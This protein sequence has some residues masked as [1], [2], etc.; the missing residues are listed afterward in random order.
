MPVRMRHDVRCGHRLTPWRDGPSCALG[1]DVPVRTSLVDDVECVEHGL[2]A[3]T[4]RGL[5]RHTVLEFGEPALGAN[6]SQNHD[7]FD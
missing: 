7:L 6:T 1:R 3:E 4:D 2:A 5:F